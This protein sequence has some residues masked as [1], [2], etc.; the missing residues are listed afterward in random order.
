MSPRSLGIAVVLLVSVGATGMGR[1]VAEEPR[2][3]RPPSRRAGAVS[4]PPQAAAYYEYVTR[5][6]VTRF[7]WQRIP[8]LVDLPEAVRQGKA[9]ERPILLW[10]AGDSPL[11]RC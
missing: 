8:W 4:L 11:Q 3:P 5:P 6:R 7:N 1:V 2:V 9:E 10:V